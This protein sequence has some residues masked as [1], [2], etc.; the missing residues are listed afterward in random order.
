MNTSAKN[1]TTSFG[2]NSEDVKNATIKAS[3]INPYTKKR[4]VNSF[5]NKSSGITFSENKHNS[6]KTEPTNFQQH[7]PSDIGPYASFSQAFETVED[8]SHYGKEISVAIKQK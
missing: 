6:Q 4:Q 7:R 3:V 2:K 5:T 1:E 8:F